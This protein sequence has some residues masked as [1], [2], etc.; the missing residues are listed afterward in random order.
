MKI[1]DYKIGDKVRIR[2]VLVGAHA[3]GYLFLEGMRKHCG[4]VSKIT[5]V[6]DWVIRLECTGINTGWMPEWFDP[7]WFDS[8][9]FLS[10]LDFDI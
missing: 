10:D 4:T 1:L 9:E 2:N 7:D 3:G 8:D 6:H 5:E